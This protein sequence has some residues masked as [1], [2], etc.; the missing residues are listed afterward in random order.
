MK[1]SNTHRVSPH[2]VKEIKIKTDP[3]VI[4]RSKITNDVFKSTLFVIAS[5][6]L[7]FVIA[8]VVW[9]AYKAAGAF[10]GEDRIGFWYFLFGNYYDG[11]TYF[12]AGF[13]VVNTLWTS[14]VALLI[15][16]PIS[17]MSALFIVRVA[18]K[19]SKPSLMAVVAI[20][21]AIPSVIYGS[22]GSIVIDGFMVTYLGMQTG[23]ALAIILTLTMMIMPTI[24]LVSIAS[25]NAVDTKMEQSSLALGATRQQTSLLVT[26]KAASGG[27]LVGAMLGIG[28][29]LGEATAVAMVAAQPNYGPSFGLLNNVRLLT[30]TMLTGFLEV[31]PGTIQEASI[32]AMGLLLLI[33]IIVVFSTMKYVEKKY[34]FDNIAKAEVKKSTEKRKIFEK[35]NTKGIQSLDSRERK[36]YEWY[37]FEDE[38]NLAKYNKEQEK[39]RQ[40]AA[41]VT[42]PS[43]PTKAYQ[44]NATSYKKRKTRQISIV[45]AIFSSIGILLLLGIITFLFVVGWPSL[46]W[47]FLTNRETGIIIPLINTIIL[48]FLTLIF[49]VPIGILTG[50]YFVEFAKPSKFNNIANSAIDMLAGVP[51]LIFGLIGASLFLPLVPD[52]FVLLAAAL[53]MTFILLPTIVKTTENAL[54]SVKKS[55]KEAALAL[56]ATRTNAAMKVALPQSMP[57]ITSGVIL[58]IGRIIGESTAIVMVLG[59]LQYATVGESVA[60]G[61]VTLA[62]YIWKL[63]SMETIPWDQVCATGVVILGLILLLTIMSMYIEKRRWNALGG[64]LAASATLLLSLWFVLGWLAIV[65]LVMLGV[66][67]LGNAMW[68]NRLKIKLLMTRLQTKLTSGKTKELT[69]KEA[70]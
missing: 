19:W 68:H 45:T 57:E 27:I 65:S 43:N 44:L 52:N 31:D 35:V 6:A 17:V 24:T 28:R 56:G 18:P 26:L 10:V 34:N 58:S 33:V 23:T 8:M 59:T 64:I 53:T 16:T 38:K 4:K 54:R 15:A 55:Q 9:M 61:G 36:L 67:I 60:N 5:L 50:V 63:T 11:V 29:A 62:T 25:I 70:V 30:A 21:A 41:L 32:F 69:S 66:V 2:K 51:S 42:M 14:I 49:L 12:A 39:K 13:M 7:F 20:L 47:D 46:T 22:F 3:K 37:V 1:N 48:I 40:A